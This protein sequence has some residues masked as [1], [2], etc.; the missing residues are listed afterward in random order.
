MTRAVDLG[1]ALLGAR[2]EIVHTH[3]RAVMRL[4]VDLSA[5]GRAIALGFVEE[6][7]GDVRRGDT[8][9]VRVHLDGREAPVVCLRV[10][11]VTRRHVT[12]GAT[13]VTWEAVS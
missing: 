5:T 7:L 11:A 4:T 6:A 2:I 1:L 13:V 10:R 9:A 8:L 12:T 3:P